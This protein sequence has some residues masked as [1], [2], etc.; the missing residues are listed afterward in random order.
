MSEPTGR[1]LE[2]HNYLLAHGAEQADNV[3]R[4]LSM[5]AEKECFPNAAIVSAWFWSG[6]YRQH[7]WFETSLSR[8][9]LDDSDLPIE[10]LGDLVLR[11]VAEYEQAGPPL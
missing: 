9:L 1:E 3:A 2:L 7:F 11:S 5:Q 10:I 4:T 6:K 8:N